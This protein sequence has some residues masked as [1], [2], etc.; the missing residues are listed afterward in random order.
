[1]THIFLYLTIIFFIEITKLN[2]NLDK[3]KYNDNEYYFIHKD[4]IF[5]K[6]QLLL[7]CLIEKEFK[8]RFLYMQSI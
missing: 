2:F 7:L 6:I 8:K 1:M 3:K 4:I 5:D